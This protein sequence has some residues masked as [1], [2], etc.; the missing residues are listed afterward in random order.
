MWIPFPYIGTLND[1][2]LWCGRQWSWC[3]LAI[4]WSH[5]CLRELHVQSW[6]QGSAFLFICLD[7]STLDVMWGSDFNVVL[8]VDVWVM[9]SA[10]IGVLPLGTHIIFLL[11][12][13]AL[14][15]CWLILW[16]DVGTSSSDLVFW[17]VSLLT[18]TMGDNPF[19]S[20]CPQS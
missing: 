18:A 16:N 3:P 15:A 14:L 20:S 6:L 17:P 7:R 1:G 9:S 2:N 10:L 12:P 11:L 4:F 19:S 13:T 8:A 5:S